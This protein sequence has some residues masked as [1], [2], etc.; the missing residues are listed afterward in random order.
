MTGASRET[1][2]QRVQ[3]EVTQEQYDAIRAA[4]LL[5]CEREL[6]GDIEGVLQTLTPDCVYAHPQSGATWEGHD[7]AR[8]FY[9][10]F[11]GA[12]P[13]NQWELHDVV[14]GPQGIMSNVTMTAHQRHPF[15]G[16]DQT[17][18]AVRWRLNNMFP[19]DPDQRKFSGETLYFFRPETD[20]FVSG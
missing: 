10:A 3:R 12:F 13:D 18:H 1:I 6:E 9:E 4:F 17:G 7:G 19:W 11:L 2:E 8:R 15:L 14:I 16:V 20:Y 5:H